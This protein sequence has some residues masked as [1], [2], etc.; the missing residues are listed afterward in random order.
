MLDRAAN[1]GHGGR[2]TARQMQRGIWITRQVRA[3]VWWAQGVR[4]RCL[5]F[6]LR[7]WIDAGLDADTVA[8]E[9]HSWMLTW[10]PA[11]PAEYIR[12]QLAKQAAAEHVA[13]ELEAEGWDEEEASGA[14]FASEPG[15]VRSVLDGLAQG[16]ATIPPARQSRDWTTSPTTTRPPTWPRS[17]PSPARREP[18]HEGRDRVERRR[19]GPSSP[20]ERPRRGE[21]HTA[22]GPHH[23]NRQV[24][25]VPQ[26]RS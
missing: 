2:R 16:L 26:G 5:E 25:V 11:R 3:R 21:D 4:L 23:Q 17:S 20:A 6:V 24:N 14:L 1:L 13:A 18:R 7:L 22:A 9:L 15:L 10:R 12:V 8:A 19:P